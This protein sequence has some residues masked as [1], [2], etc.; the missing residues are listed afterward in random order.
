VIDGNKIV[1]ILHGLTYTAQSTPCLECYS[2]F[3]DDAI[4]SCDRFVRRNDTTV[5]VL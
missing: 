5:I 1:T 3:Y 4:L 2:S